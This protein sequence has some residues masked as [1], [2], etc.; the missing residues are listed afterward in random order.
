MHATDYDKQIKTKAKVVSSHIEK[1]SVIKRIK[2]KAIKAADTELFKST[3][4]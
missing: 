1:I 3:S 4:L 2:Y